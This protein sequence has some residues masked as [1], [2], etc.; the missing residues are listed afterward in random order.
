M[1]T[2]LTLD[3]ATN[4][5][6]AYGPAGQIEK[7]GSVRLRAPKTARRDADPMHVGWSN[8]AFWLRDTWIF[9]KPDEI[10]A[11][12]PLPPGDQSSGAAAQTALGLLAVVH[13]MAAMYEIPIRYAYVQQWRKHYTGKPFHKAP[14]TF[15]PNRKSGERNRMWNKQ[16]TIERA[17][18]LRHIPMDCKDDNRADACGM[19][20][21]ASHHFHRKGSPASFNLF[22]A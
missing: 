9:D 10:V 6:W 16:V 13:A 1:P 7:S 3:I 5:G 2:I 15:M 11:E 18:L 21:W 4:T 8:V 19:H 12:A 20:D 17:R 22:G 14:A